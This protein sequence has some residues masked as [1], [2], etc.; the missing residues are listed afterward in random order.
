MAAFHFHLPPNHVGFGMLGVT[1][2]VKHKA[3]GLLN[4]SVNQICEP[5]QNSC[6][7]DGRKD[8]LFWT[9]LYPGSFVGSLWIGHG[10]AC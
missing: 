2:P 6:F 10:L 7:L 3:V 8:R 9:D 4:T 5:C 1:E